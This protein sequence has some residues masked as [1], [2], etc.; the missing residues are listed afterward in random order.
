MPWHWE[1]GT[2]ARA[3]ALGCP[4]H[5]SPGGLGSVPASHPVP[6]GPLAL[7]PSCPAH[8]PFRHDPPKE[9][10]PLCPVRCTYRT[11]CPHGLPAAPRAARSPG[12]PGDTFLVPSRGPEQLPAP[13]QLHALDHILIATA[14]KHGLQRVHRRAAEIRARARLAQAGPSSA[15]RTHVHTHPP[16]LLEDMPRDPPACSLLPVSLPLGSTV[17]PLLLQELKGP[18]PV[19]R[20]PD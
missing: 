16:M 18:Q 8:P 7:P 5:T 20:P 2:R 14:D 17:G 4:E 6:S 15:P 19:P 3:G 11:C 10:F 12:Q 9:A 13:V 1:G